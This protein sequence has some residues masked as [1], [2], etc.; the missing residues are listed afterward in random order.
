MDSE[1]DDVDIPWCC[2]S[3]RRCR[4]CQFELEEGNSV[5]ACVISHISSAFASTHTSQI[6]M[7]G[8]ACPFSPSNR[9]SPPIT[10]PLSASRFTDAIHRFSAPFSAQTVRP[11]G[12]AISAL[13]SSIVN[14]SLS[15]AEWSSFLAA[16]E[17][18]FKPSSFEGR[19]RFDF[20]RARHRSWQ[21]PCK[22]SSFP[23]SLH[24]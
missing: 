17:Y 3:Q 6:S 8:D 16:T 23:R 19:R 11:A 5:V 12:W 7:T 20:I 13:P 22:L 24:L 9:A 2:F 14:V 21:R 1:D 10:T 15:C 18:S 4:L